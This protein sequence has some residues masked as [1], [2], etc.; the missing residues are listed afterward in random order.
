[1]IKLAEFTATFPSAEGDL[2]LKI[3]EEDGEERFTLVGV[4]REHRML[5]AFMC[6]TRVIVLFYLGAVGCIFLVNEVGYMDLLMN[7]VALAFILEVD[8][9]LFG[10]IVRHVTKD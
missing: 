7:A 2:G 10:S 9:I 4:S 1:M 6:A 5:I 8:E 3:Y